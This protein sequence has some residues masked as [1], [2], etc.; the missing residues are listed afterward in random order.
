MK[1]IGCGFLIMVLILFFLVAEFLPDEAARI[2]SNNPFESG[3][4]TTIEDGTHNKGIVL[5]QEESD[6][7]KEE[8]FNTDSLLYYIGKGEG[9]VLANFGE[10]VRKDPSAYG[11]IWWVYDSDDRY[12]QIGIESGQVVT[13]IGMGENV[14]IEPFTI[15]SDYHNL[16]SQYQ[17]EE[18]VSLSKGTNS[19]RFE[20]SAEEL[21][22]R[23]LIEYEDKWVQL[24]FDTFTN[25]LSSIRILDRETLLVKR[26]YSMT[27]RGSIPE[28]PTLSADVWKAVEAGAARQILDMTN[29]IRVR[30]QLNRLEW[31]REVSDVAYLH[32][33]DMSTNQYF[34]HTSPQFG[35]LKDRLE[36]N[37][38]LFQ[39]AGENI[40]AQYVDSLAAVEG[41][42]NSEGHRVNL[43][44]DEFTHLGV[45]IYEKY[46][47]QNFIT[48]WN[49]FD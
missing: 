11:Y 40:A 8:I 43:L 9:D 25:K 10:P 6:D 32:S 49:A 1:R 38:V 44:N 4:S 26:P 20:L 7:K 21:R 48:P 14:V 33:E 27:Y 45:G 24:Y 23:P 39:L 42:L 5:N 37:D 34:S 28:P 22:S 46:Y 15:G 30:H 47:T 18:Q 35:Q 13:A 2:L 12:V 41:W 3:S 17:F 16:L 36:R 29:M 19:Y 31:D